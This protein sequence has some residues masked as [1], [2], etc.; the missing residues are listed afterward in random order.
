MHIFNGGQDVELYLLSAD[1]Q[2]EL[3]IW[4]E[5]LNKLLRI[6]REWNI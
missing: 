1:N 3:N 2:T 5:D 4:M 6:G